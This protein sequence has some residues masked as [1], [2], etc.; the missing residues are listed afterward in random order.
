M[1]INGALVSGTKTEDSFGSGTGLYTEQKKTNIGIRFDV[2]SFEKLIIRGGIG[3]YYYS[4]LYTRQG[5]SNDTTLMI[6]LRYVLYDCTYEFRTDNTL[7]RGSAS[8]RYD[9]T[10]NLAKEYNASVSINGGKTFVF[11]GLR[12]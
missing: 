12:K 5:I 9:T 1:Y 7:Y 4:Y 10:D 11:S 2:F 3:E 8:I 6:E